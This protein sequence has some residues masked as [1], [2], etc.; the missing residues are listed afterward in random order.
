[1][2]FFIYTSLGRKRN[3]HPSSPIIAKVILP[4]DQK[5]SCTVTLTAGYH[6]EVI[7]SL[8]PLQL[9]SFYCIH[10][11]E[12]SFSKIQIVQLLAF[13]F[14]KQ[15]SGSYNRIGI[16]PEPV[17]SYF[18]QEKNKTFP[19]QKSMDTVRSKGF[20]VRFFIGSLQVGPMLP[21]SQS[22][23]T[24]PVQLPSWEKVMGLGS[25]HG[26]Y[27]PTCHL[28]FL[29]RSPS[30]H[31]L[32]QPDWVKKAAVLIVLPPQEVQD[33]CWP[34]Q[35]FGGDCSENICGISGALWSRQS[36]LTEDV[37]QHTSWDGQADV[38][39]EVS[40]GTWTNSWRRKGIKLPACLCRCR[41]RK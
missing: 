36:D 16:F 28:R 1:M 34:F 41:L 30:H 19:E 15:T 8:C 6:W 2:D 29:K 12:N 27:Q 5:K 18:A 31:V 20:R 4:K 37:H 21:P 26:K 10:C 14:L 22:T 7:I 9:T 35:L 3:L 24:S 25:G 23:H 39:T 40:G 13:E 38:N 11:L 17:F 33:C 32:S